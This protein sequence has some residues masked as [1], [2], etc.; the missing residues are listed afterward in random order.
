MD[1]GTIDAITGNLLARMAQ[2]EG[3]VER[4]RATMA[5]KE[6]GAGAA[7]FVHHDVAQPK[8]AVAK[9]SGLELRELDED[10]EAEEETFSEVVASEM[11]DL[12]DR[13]KED[14]FGIRE[15]TYTSGE[16]DY[17]V[18]V[19]GTDPKEEEED[20]PD[21]DDPDDDPEDE[22]WTDPDVPPDPDVGPWPPEDDDDW[23]NPE[24]DDGNDISDAFS[25]V[26]DSGGYCN[27]I[28]GGGGGGSGETT[29]HAGPG[30]NG[31]SQT[32]CGK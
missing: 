26:P 32:P 28:G 13:E 30:G 4:L 20:D 8:V 2:L 21:I 5:D 3:E 10:E 17:K 31:V 29:P 22:D 11:L 23:E 6:E 16:K 12:K 25:G 7:G 18:K 14:E 24:F 9:D 19:L 27:A 15:I 1:E